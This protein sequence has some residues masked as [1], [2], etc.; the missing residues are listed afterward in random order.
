MARAYQQI[1]RSGLVTGRAQ[2]LFIDFGAQENA[3]VVALVD[4]VSQ[5]GGRP[6]RAAEAYNFPEL[7]SARDVFDFLY[8]LEELIAAS[9]LGQLT[10]IQDRELR[11][12]IASIHNV[13]GQ[14]AVALAD[15]LNLEPGLAFAVGQG[16]NDTLSTIEPYFTATTPTEMPRTGF[17]GLRHAVQSVNGPRLVE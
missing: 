14:H 15:L 9:Y 1:N 8:A 13:E 2:D 5:M 16:M 3:H 7:N 11:T 4:R 17:G 6:V 12:T 10:I